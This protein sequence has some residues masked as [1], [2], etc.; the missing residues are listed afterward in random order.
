MGAGKHAVTQEAFDALVREGMDEFDMAPHEAV[1][2]AVRTLTMQGA[3]LAGAPLTMQGADLA[4][5]P[6]L[7]A[8]RRLQWSGDHPLTFPSNPLPPPS[9]T[10][11]QAE[12]GCPIPH[13]LAS[14]PLNPIRHAPP[15]RV[16]ARAGIVTAYSATGQRAQHPAAAAATQLTAALAGWKERQAGGDGAYSGAHFH[17]PSTPFRFLPTPAYPVFLPSPSSPLLCVATAPRPQAVVEALCALRRALSPSVAGTPGGQAQQE[18]VGGEEGAAVAG[19]SA[20][21]EAAVVAGRNEG[22]PAAVGAL[23][24]V[25]GAVER[26]EKGG[27]AEEGEEEGGGL[28]RAVCDALTCSEEL[29]T[30][31]DALMHHPRSHHAT[32]SSHAA[33]P[34]AYLPQLNH[35]A[36]LLLHLF[37]NLN[38]FPF[39]PLFLPDLSPPLPLPPR[40]AVPGARDHF[41]RLSGPSLLATALP[42]PPFSS[43]S[44][45]RVAAVGSTVRA[46]SV[47]NEVI[48]EALMD[49]AL[50]VK[51]LNAIV[52]IIHSKRTADG[53]G[54]VTDV[55][56]AGSAMCACCGAVRALV[57]NDDVRVAA[58]NTFSNARTMADAGAVHV[59]LTAAAAFPAH[60]AVLPAVL[61]ALKAIAVNVRSPAHLPLLTFPCSRSPAH[62]PLLL[63]LLLL[64]LLMLL[65]LLLLLMLLLLPLWTATTMIIT[66]IALNIPPPGPPPLPSFPMPRSTLCIVLHP[67]P[68]P[69]LPPC[70]PRRT[71]VAASL[72]SPGCPSCSPTSGLPSPRTALPSLLPPPH[73]WRSKP[74]PL[75]ILA[76]LV[77]IRL[78]SCVPRSHRQL[79][80][81][82]A[83]KVLIVE[84]GGIPV[85]VEAV[86]AFVDDGA[87]LQEVWGCASRGMGLCFK[88]YG[89]VL[90]EVWGCASRGMGLCFKRYG[91]AAASVQLSKCGTDE[92]S[93]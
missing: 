1:D 27:E 69:V 85:L 33:R 5:A 4:G 89:A 83:N 35:P 76:S 29:L 72:L 84:T 32:P 51:L 15:P 42:V 6:L 86:K 8:S 30:H 87:V 58:S 12:S 17:L 43:C 77:Q 65:L 64:L 19:R 34:H 23:G 44:L 13:A 88:R 24:V 92:A 39:A 41:F 48:K 46:A 82:D 18:G 62:L 67:T 56:K 75:V 78:F 54:S 80:G 60:V 74:P 55:A 22:L 7:S 47:E 79:A 73:C 26:G 63:L 91:A 38:A 28:E 11:C 9:H 93:L 10:L 36:P 14:W 68:H 90:Q 50:H 52:G 20:S 71:S 37:L 59:L 2:D 66:T 21:G 3:D 31:G 81:S 25:L 40:T 49:A 61:A 70:A 16:H 57:T 53:D 45:T